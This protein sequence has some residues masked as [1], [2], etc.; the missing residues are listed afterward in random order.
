MNFFS[1]LFKDF[2]NKIEFAFYPDNERLQLNCSELLVQGYLTNVVGYRCIKEIASAAASIEVEAYTGDKTLEKHE[3][4]DFIKTPNSVQSYEAFIQQ[5]ITSYLIKEAWIE[6]QKSGVNKII[7]LYT[8]PHQKMTVWN[9]GNSDYEP[10]YYEYQ[11]KHRSSGGN[12]SSYSF[13]K[14]YYQEGRR[15]IARDSLFKEEIVR[16]YDSSPVNKFHSHSPLEAAVGSVMNFHEAMKWNYSIL[17][18]GGVAAAHYSTEANYSPKEKEDL[19]RRIEEHY[20]SMSKRG[21]PLISFG[22]LKADKLGFSP[23]EMHFKELLDSMGKMIC[24]AFNVPVPM[25]YDDTSTYNNFESSKIHFYSDTVIPILRRVLNVL[26]DLLEIN[27]KNVRLRPN[28]ESIT[29]L[30]GERN[31]KVDTIVNLVNSGIISASQAAEELGYTYEENIE[32]EKN[33]K[34]LENMKDNNV[35][36]ESK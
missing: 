4:L 3:I 12:L 22:G 27:Y 17:K 31:E 25:V 11:Y 10:D 16:I 21:R 23:Q 15:W 26:S 24:V 6:A 9:P 8:L 19:A 28:E 36:E 13:S 29:A 5:I 14:K 1:D 34:I 2:K 35:N 20:S 32:I 30:T 7:S 33:K 18:N